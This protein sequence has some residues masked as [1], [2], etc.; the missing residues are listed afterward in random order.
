M[1]SDIGY[2]S[3]DCRLQIVDFQ[4][5]VALF[6]IFYF[7]SSIFHFQRPKQECVGA[8]QTSAENSASAGYPS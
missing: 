8:S 7:L 6:S 1:D 2:L 4:S 3:L 5:T